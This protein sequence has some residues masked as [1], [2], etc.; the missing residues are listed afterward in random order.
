[1]RKLVDLL[2]S[3]EVRVNPVMRRAH[4]ELIISLAVPFLFM[5]VAAIST[6]FLKPDLDLF[7][8]GWFSIWLLLPIAQWGLLRKTG[9][10][11]LV[12]DTLS[13]SL[14]MFVGVGAAY[15]G[16]IASSMVIGLCILPLENMLSGDRRRVVLSIA[17][18]LVCLAVLWVLG[19]Q[20]LLPMDRTSDELRNT[21]RP[22]AV[23]FV[24]FYSYLVADALIRHRLAD[25]Q[26]LADT[27]NQFESLF[28]TAPI[29][30]LEQDWSQ[31]RRLIN[32]LADD[33]VS[34]LNRHLADHPDMLKRLIGSIRTIR[35]NK[36]TL[37]LY[38]VLGQAE[39]IEHLAPD[40]LSEEE[41]RNYRHWIVSFA[42]SDTGSYLNETV[43]RRQRG[44]QVYTRI[45]SAIIPEHRHDWLRVVTT[46]GDVSDRKRAEL[47]LRSAKEEADRANRAKS[48]FL[49]SMSHELRTPLNAIIGFSDIMRQQMFGPV[50]ESRYIAYAGDIHDSGQHLLNL[51][52]DMLDLSRIES[53]KYEIR[54]EWLS[55]Q[56]LLDW[57]LNMTEPQ[58]LS[59]GVEVNVSVAAAMPNFRADRRAMRQ[60]LLNL[61]SNA[62]KF[63]PSGGNITLSA[64]Q[65]SD[66]GDIVLEV[67][68]SGKGIPAHLLD[69][70]TEPFVQAGD[71]AT[72]QET[73][74]GL[75]L[76]ITKS[77][78]HLHGGKLVL[79][80]TEHVGTIVTIRLPS[81]RVHDGRLEGT[82]QEKMVNDSSA[83]LL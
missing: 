61:F 79:V 18:V 25:E 83:A 82:D 34:D 80:S 23:M 33:G 50:G 78:V 68:D 51:I 58:I 63:T 77:L 54:E 24:M 7:D 31:T 38:R 56:D 36:A 64:F 8:L 21:L 69:T 76:S 75:G 45:R 9:N 3:P 26:T 43:I 60:I 57:V 13:L 70:I 40:N 27:E 1:M 81:A 41:L 55:A 15:S 6:V 28:E 30:I 52:N 17:A 65:E 62:L 42:S 44:G 59:R 73:G 72:R 49:A 39:L 20:R 32:R 66:D 22:L 19:E 5:P 11:R 47:E 53:G 29:S 67:A 71:P 35:V 12:R 14:L 4:M 10:V 74:T 37:T 48:Q 2:L 16:G 46:V